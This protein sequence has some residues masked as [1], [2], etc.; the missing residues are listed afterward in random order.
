MKLI[1]EFLPLFK[2]IWPKIL[3]NKV[4]VIKV[5]K[6]G[7]FHLDKD[8][9]GTDRIFLN[10]RY[11]AKELINKIRARTFMPHPGAY[12][13]ENGKKLFVRVQL[14]YAEKSE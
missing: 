7:S 9:D 2:K 6:K 8:F 12:F 14:E 3:E 1:N 10:K 11:S 4:K 5:N 13:I